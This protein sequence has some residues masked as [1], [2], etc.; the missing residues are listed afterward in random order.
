[1]TNGPVETGFTVYEDFMSYS[2]GVYKHTTGVAKGGHAVKIVGWGP[3]Y[4]ICANSWGPSWGVEGFF[5]I[6]F[7]EC[8]IDDAAYG[9]V[10]KL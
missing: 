7:G 4:W 5:N 9:C 3:G 8:G 6:A 10:P 2:G 1:M